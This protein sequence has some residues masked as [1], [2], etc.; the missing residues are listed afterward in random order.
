MINRFFKI[1][2]KKIIIK[3]NEHKS[4]QHTFPNNKDK[5]ST[6]HQASISRDNSGINNC[7]NSRQFFIPNI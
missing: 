1:N 5:K 4:K 3:K 2:L 7:F 6:N